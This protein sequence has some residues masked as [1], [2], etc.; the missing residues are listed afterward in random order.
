MRLATVMF[1]LLVVFGTAGV[2]AYTALVALL[3]PLA[4]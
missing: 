1:V 4:R 2:M 3:G